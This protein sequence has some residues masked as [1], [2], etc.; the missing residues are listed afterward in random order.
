AFLDATPLE[1]LPSHGPEFREQC[2][3]ELRAARKSGLLF[4]DQLQPEDLAKRAADLA[5][6]E[7]PAALLE[8]E[9]HILDG[10]A[11]E[12]RAAGHASLAHLGPR[13][14]GAAPPLLACAVRFFFRLAV[15]RDDELYRGLSYAQWESLGEA[16]RQGFAELDR[17][18][19]VHGQRLDE[20]LDVL[21]E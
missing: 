5:R 1:G 19:S 3:R 12:L 7:D 16:Q 21:G 14:A 8:R 17:V 11:G 15:E 4:A 2:L 13:R 18:L 9:G 6:F 10:M 20:V